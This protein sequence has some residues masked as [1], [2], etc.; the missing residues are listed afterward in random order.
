M[1]IK[2]CRRLKKKVDRGALDY[3]RLCAVLGRRWS[4][5]T[6]EHF[7]TEMDL[8]DISKL[9][10]FLTKEE[11]DVCWTGRRRSDHRKL[12]KDGIIKG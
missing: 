6:P 1:P 3:D 7:Y 10:P 2:G 12:R 4:Y 8:S 5:I 9:T 11:F